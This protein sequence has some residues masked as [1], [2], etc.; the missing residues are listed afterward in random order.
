MSGYGKG[1]GDPERTLAKFVRLRIKLA[2][3]STSHV[4]N[5]VSCAWHA[6]VIDST[7]QE[8]KL[9]LASENV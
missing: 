9:L 8:E 2:P 1:M 4:K 5:F 3:D 6:T 7:K